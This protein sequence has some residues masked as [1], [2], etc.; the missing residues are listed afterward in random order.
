MSSFESK[1]T[2][3]F[4]GGCWLHDSHLWMDII[5]YYSAINLSC[6]LTS[7]TELRRNICSIRTDE[8]KQVSSHFT[9]IVISLFGDWFVLFQIPT[10][11]LTFIES[12]SLFSVMLVYFIWNRFCLFVVSIVYCTSRASFITKFQS[13]FQMSSDLNKDNI[14]VN[15]FIL[16]VFHK[17]IECFQVN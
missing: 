16:F 5:S 17:E 3:P 11:K 4:V 8:N 9:F 7:I 10:W 14:F 2:R 6:R 15:L 13:A 12:V 1:Q